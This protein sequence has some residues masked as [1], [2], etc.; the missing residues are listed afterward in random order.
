VPLP[1]IL[2]E[3]LRADDAGVRDAMRWRMAFQA[4]AAT[5]PRTAA[6]AALRLSRHRSVAVVWAPFRDHA[7]FCSFAELA[8]CAP[9]TVD[10]FRAWAAERGL[11][12]RSA[13]QVTVTSLHEKPESLF[14]SENGSGAPPPRRTESLA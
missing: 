12:G 3:S 8:T 2:G 4:L 7:E 11:L 9:C 5:H 1:A 14:P 13:A 6:I 10:R